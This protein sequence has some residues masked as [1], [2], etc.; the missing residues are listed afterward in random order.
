MT[1]LIGLAIRSS[2][3]LAAGL[4]LSA[5][6]AKR[7]AALRHRVLTAAFLAAAVVMP[8]S[9]ALPEWTVTLPARSVERDVPGRLPR[10]SGR[11]PGSPRLL[12]PS[13]R[14]PTAVSPIV[15]AWL[16]GAA[17]RG[18]HPDRGLGAGASC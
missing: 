17:Y 15:I 9:L 10:R 3:M 16:A 8:L 13:H 4:L 1:L 5:C 14:H 7:S 12:R 6:L 2:V 18:R 11:G